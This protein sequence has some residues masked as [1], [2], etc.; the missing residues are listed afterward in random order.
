MAQAIILLYEKRKGLRQDCSED[1]TQPEESARLP[2]GDLKD[3]VV[4]PAEGEKDT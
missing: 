1:P 2:L 3:E 4:G